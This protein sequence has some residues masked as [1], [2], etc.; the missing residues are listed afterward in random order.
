MKTSRVRRPR[1]PNTLRERIDG[2]IND[3]FAQLML[4]EKPEYDRRGLRNEKIVLA[5]LPS[6]VKLFERHHQEVVSCWLADRV[7]IVL[8]RSGRGR[9]HEFQSCLP[10][11]ALPEYFNVPDEDKAG[12][13][14][15]LQIDVTPA[16]LRR[17]ADHRREIITGHEVELSKITLLLETA[18]ERGCDEYSPVRSVFFPDDDD[19]AWPDEHAPL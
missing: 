15:K 9:E 16:E 14:W 17:I 12:A 10:E 2:L 3:G 8:G 11:L 18:L 1:V 19:P 6:A 13:G 7:P 5:I 4:T